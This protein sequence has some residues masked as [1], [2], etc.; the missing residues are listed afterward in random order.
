MQELERR[1]EEAKSNQDY[2]DSKEASLEE[3]IR[4]RNGHSRCGKYA[5]NSDT[6]AHREIH[7]LIEYIEDLEEAKE[8]ENG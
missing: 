5:M 7:I 6:F 1:L 3:L 2:W 8:K 4:L